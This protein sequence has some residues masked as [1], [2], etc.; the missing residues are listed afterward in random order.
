ML[1]GALTHIY[2]WHLYGVVLWGHMKNKIHISTCR[3]RIDTIPGKVCANLVQEARKHNLDQE[4]NMRS[5]DCLKNPY[6]CF[7]ENYV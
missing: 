7:H 4:T 3:R 5:H 2:A 1:E 6:L